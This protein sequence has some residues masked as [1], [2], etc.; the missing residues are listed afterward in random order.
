MKVIDV[1]RWQNN[2]DFAKV[3]ASGIEGVI[4]KAGGSDSGFY[5]DSKFEQNYANA[6]AV[7]LHVGTYYFVGKGCIS[8]VDGRAD[9]ERFANLI[10]GKQFDLPVYMDVESTPISARTGATD[11]AIAFCS[12]LESKGY[13]VGIYASDISGFK[14]RLDY[15]RLKDRFTSWV[16]RYGSEP[17]YATKW[18]MWQYTS[19]GRVNGIAGNVDMD[20]CRKDFPSIIIN[21]GFNGYS[22]STPTP[23]PQPT[24]APSPAPTPA[25]KSDDEIAN[26]VIQGKWGNG[27]DRKNRLAAAGYNYSTIQGLVNQK[28]GGA[29]P[30]RPAVQYYTV[31]RGDNLTRIANKYGTSVNQLVAWNGI[32]N[33][34][35]IYAGQKLRVK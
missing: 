24:P 12:Y 22:K 9:G 14:D 25:K 8:T 26:E 2:I 6:K 4:I 10:A 13:Y 34:N 32:K 7:G 27:E 23:A 33:A 5:K 20:D 16:A 18:D 31:Q 29:K 3:K 21:G 35:L 19:T 17:K 30:I 11:A 1:S 28:L 15:S